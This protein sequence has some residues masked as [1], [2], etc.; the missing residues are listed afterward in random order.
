MKAG[1][2]TR[3]YID[4]NALSHNLAQVRAK[5]GGRKVLGVVK[6]DAYGHGAVE[7]AR[8]LEHEGVEALGVA[9]AEE[10]IALRAAGI[11]LP[12]IILG[13]VFEHQAEDVLEH[14][15][16]PV[17][18]ADAQAQAFSKAAA[19]RGVKMPV[20]VKVDTGMGRVGMPPAEAVEF[21]AALNAMPGLTVQGLM[22]HL[23]DVSGADKSFA[24]YQITR[25]GEAVEALKARGID[26]PLLHASGSAAIIEFQPAHFNMVRPG[27]MLYGCYPSEHMKG[28]LTLKPVM[29]V[30]TAV[31]HLK[32]MEKGLPISYG[33]TYHTQ[34][35][36]LIATLPIG[37]AD[38]LDRGLSNKGSVLIGGRRCPIVGTICMDL[39][40]VDVTEAPE[41]KVGDEAVI[42]GRQGGEE[43]TTD[44]VAG[45]LDTISYEVLCGIS[46]RVKREYIY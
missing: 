32:M 44:E 16:T 15:L 43:I 20:H 10:G 23:S 33:R 24:E 6:A 22:T 39:V 3:A 30:K 36:S 41:V 45:L 28:L 17:V 26:V 29:S 38:G 4:L 7:V 5:A 8:W 2:P 37:Y 13:G 40:M 18:F 12:I 31:M 27:I 21:V 42:I 1:R 35:P 9:L 46:G 19:A 14:G 34:R 25:F 11:G